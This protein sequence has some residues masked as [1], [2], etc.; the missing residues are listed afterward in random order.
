MS[1]SRAC[2]AFWCAHNWMW[3]VCVDG[4]C[5]WVKEVAGER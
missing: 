4:N 1:H 5:E 2:K 3:D